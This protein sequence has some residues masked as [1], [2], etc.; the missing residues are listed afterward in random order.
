MRKAAI[1][2]LVCLPFL[3]FAGLVLGGGVFVIF[4]AASCTQSH[5]QEQGQGQPPPTAAQPSN[6][7]NANAQAIL[8]EVKRE[9]LPQEA[10]IDAIDA[11]L[12]E[13]DLHNSPVA[14]DHDSVGLFQQRPSQGWGTEQQIMDP[15]YATSKFLE[16]LKAIPNWQ[17]LPVQSAVQEVQ[18][19]GAPQRYTQFVGQ[20]QQLVGQLWGGVAGGVAAQPRP[21]DCPQQQSGP[22][23]GG[24]LANL[25]WPVVNP[26]PT[27]GWKQQ[28]PVPQWPA[29]LPGTRVNPAQISPQCVAGALWSWA[30]E[31]LSDPQ[32]ASP[33]PINGN[34]A[35]MFPDA[36]RKGFQLAGQ[37][38]PGEIVVWKAGS[39]YGPYGHVGTVTAVQGD[40]FETVEQNLLN[41]TSDLSAHWGTWD[42]RSVAWPD[43]NVEGFVKAPPAA[44]T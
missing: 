41:E 36:Q 5:G 37:P 9:S 22:P 17:F 27:P 14:R 10:G 6:D 32:F 23:P 25:P 8:A 12:A 30:T 34:A 28:I 43:S 15:A 2:A 38:A 13:D 24:A 33:P 39:F 20:A 40:R 7:Q 18:R 29:G 19:S 3:L 4:Q 11:A 21:Q 44:R 42:V 35:D 16:H 1:V 31:H 26:V